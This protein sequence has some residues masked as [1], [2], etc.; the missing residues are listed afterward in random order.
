MRYRNLN[1]QNRVRASAL[2]ELTTAVC[3]AA[4]FVSSGSSAEMQIDRSITIASVWSGV[5]RII[6]AQPLEDLIARYGRFRYIPF[7]RI[8]WIVLNGEFQIKERLD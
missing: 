1:N 8:V 7:R 5:W 2:L 3:V 4:P 6:W